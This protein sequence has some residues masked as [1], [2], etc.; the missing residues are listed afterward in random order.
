MGGEQ[1][2][3]SATFLGAFK[4]Q[5]MLQWNQIYCELPVNNYPLELHKVISCSPF[6]LYAPLIFLYNLSSENYN[7]KHILL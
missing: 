1:Y 3:E 5:D 6:C 4:P 2:L 7:A